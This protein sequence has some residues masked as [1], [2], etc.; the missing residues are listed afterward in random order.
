MVKSFAQ[1]ERAKA[2]RPVATRSS[3]ENQ[4]AK[5]PPRA[6]GRAVEEETSSG[7]TKKPRAPVEYTPATVEDYKQRF[8]AAKPEKSEL[9]KLGPDLDDDNLMMKKAVQEKVKQF[10]KELH[11]INRQRSSSQSE[12]PKQP[13]PKPEAK[14]T[15]RSK[16][17]Q[18]AKTVPKPKVAAPKVVMTT[19]SPTNAKPVEDE[20]DMADWEEI[21]QREK[22][23]LEDA[24][25][26]L[27]IKEFI[28]KLNF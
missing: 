25:K 14:P 8:G 20:Q 4:A 16:A 27:E 9:G 22:Q 7:P 18:F 21:R 26:V 15:A 11:R 23:H 6:P 13:S 17:L 10:S 28:A 19:P 12:K 2:S 24:S 3:A 5:K 1:E